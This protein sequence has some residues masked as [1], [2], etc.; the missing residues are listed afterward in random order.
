MKSL[1]F[2][3]NAI[4]KIVRKSPQ[5]ISITQIQT[6]VGRINKKYIILTLGILIYLGYIKRVEKY[7]YTAI[8]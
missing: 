5:P 3:Q 7:I 1:S 2:F 6:I 4:L 8:Y